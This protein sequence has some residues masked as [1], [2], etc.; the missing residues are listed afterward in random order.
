MSVTS[1]PSVRDPSLPTVPHV[2]ILMAVYNGAE[3]LQ[4]QLDSLAAQ[5]HGSW[6][7]LVSD[8]GSSDTTRAI[9][10]AFAKH[11]PVTVLDGPGKGAAAN[12]MSLVA[13]AQDYLPTNSWL[14]FCDQDDVWLPEKLSL[15]VSALDTLDTT[16]PALYCSRTWVVDAQLGGRKLSTARPRAPDFRNALAQNIAAGNTIL[17][18]PV[19]ARLLMQAAPEAEEVVMHDW[20]SYQL[21]TGAG[22][23]VYHDDTPTLLYRQHADNEVGANTGWRAKGQRLKRMLQGDF[24]DWNDVNIRALQT[25]RAHLTPRAIAQLDAFAALRKMPATQRLIELRHLKLYRQSRTSTFALWVAAA[26]GRL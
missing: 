6:S 9:L 26:L 22:G 4:E 1:D 21:I 10:Q 12:F 2:G 16:G 18:N 23:Q 11:H 24:R 20:W 19:G 15:A 7:L 8:D 13:C 25:H 5:T 3:C 14:A 17:L